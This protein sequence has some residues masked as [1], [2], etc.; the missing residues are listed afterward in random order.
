MKNYLQPKSLLVLLFS[1]LMLFSGLVS[2]QIEVE[3]TGALFTPEDLITNVFLGD[4]VEVTNI[5]YNGDDAAVG[6][7]TNGTNDVGMDRGIVMASGTAVTAATPNNAGGTSGG[8][9]NSTASDPDIT[10]IT[11]STPNDVAIYE[12]S[13]IPISDTLRFK[14]A[15]AS[16]EYPEYAC[17]DYNDAFG[18]F[19]S[20]PGISGPFSNNGINIAFVPDPADPTGTTFTD[21]PVTINNVNPGVVGINGTI[22]NCTPP[23]GSLDYGVYYNDNTGSNTLTYDGVLD[24]FIAQVVVTPCEEYTIKLA[25]CDAGDS[26][27]DSAVFLE[28]K[29]FGTGSLTVETATV[30]LDGTITESCSDGIL[31]FSFPGPVASD[32]HVDYT[33]FGEA[34]NGVDFEFIPGDLF[35][36]AGDSAVSVPVIAYEDGIAEGLESIGIDVQRDPCNRDTFYFYIRDNDIVNPELSDDTTVCRFEPVQLDGTLDIT[37]PPPPTFT[38]ETDYPIQVIDPNQPPPPGTPPTISEINVFGVQPPT[39]QEGVVKRVCINVDHGWISDIDAFLVSPGGQFLELTTDNGGSGNDYTETCFTPEATDPINFGSTAPNTAAPFTGDWQPE[40]VWSDLWDGEYP[41]N[42][43]WQLQIRDD[44]TADNGTLLGWSICFN[45]LYQI[46]Y[47]W[48]PSEGL[49]CDDC[50]DPIATPDSTT[51]YYLTATDTYG[52]E[53]YD[54]IT[55][56]VLDVLPAPNVTCDGVTTNSITFN[57]DE[58]PGANGYEVSINGGPWMSPTPGPL[59][60]YVSNLNLGEDVTIMVRST[61]LCDGL[62]DTLTCTTVDCTPP[63]LALTNTTDVTCNGDNNGSLSITAT[64]NFPPYE[65]SIAGIET[66]DTGVFSGLPGG[67]YDVL[68]TDIGGC[69]TSI[70][71]EILE[72][73]ALSSQEIVLGEALCNGSSE[74]SGTVVVSGGVQPYSFVWNNGSVD[75]V[76][77]NL[78]VGEYIVVVT[79]ANGCSITDSLLIVEPELLI[80]T[81]ASQAVSCNGEGDGTASVTVEG[82]VE[83]Y[84]YQWDANANNQTTATATGLNGGLYTVV[85]TD[86]QGCAGEA[87]VTVNEDPPVEL[88]INGSDAA[89]ADSNDGTATVE[90]QGGAGGVYTYQWDDPALQQTATATNLAPNSYTVV[91][92]DSNNCSE[93]ATITIE[94]PEALVVNNLLSEDASCAGLNDGIITIGVSGGAYP[95]TYEWSDNNTI[96]DSTRTD[97]VAGDYQIIITDGNDCSQTMDIF[98]GEPAPID[99]DFTIENV[100]CNGNDDGV[101]T[102]LPSGGSEPYTYQWDGNTNNQTTQSASNLPAGS[103]DVIVTDAN[104]CTNEATAIIDE[105]SDISLSLSPEDILCFGNNTGLVNTDISGGTEPYTFTWTGPNGFNSTD[106]DINSLYAGQYTLLVTDGLGCTATEQTTLI[107]PA[108]G[109]MSTMSP[110]DLICNGA[111]NGQ[112]VVSVTGGTG[113]FTYE[114]SN[115]STIPTVNNLPAG[116]HFVTITDAGNCTFV[117]T[118]FIDQQEAIIVELS[119]TGASCYNGLDGAAS[120]VNVFY[121]STPADIGSF[122]INWSNGENTVDVSNLLGGDT[123]TVTLTDALGCT[124]TESIIIDNPAEIGTVVENISDVSCYGGDDGSATVNG[125]GGTAPYSFEWDVSA[126]SQTTS[127][128][129]GLE[130]GEYFV[131]VTDGNDCS[132]TTSVEVGEPQRIEISFEAEDVLCAGQSNGSI[133]PSIEGGSPPFTYSWSNGATTSELGEVG[134]GSYGLTITDSNGCVREGAVSISAPTTITASASIEPTSCYKGRDGVIRVNSVSGGTPPYSYSIDD[135]DYH[136]GNIFV[137]LPASLYSVY[138]KDANGC[139]WQTEVNVWQPGRLNVY[140]GEDRTLQVGDSTQLH[141]FWEHE[142][143]EVEYTWLSPGSNYLVCPGGIGI[144]C[145]NPWVHITNT[146]T[147]TIEIKDEKG[148]TDED[149]VTITI[150]KYRPVHVPTAFTPNGDGVNDLLQ[151]HGRD[152]TV[153]KTFRVYDR[154]GEL[155]FQADD[156]GVNSTLIG[157]DGRFRSQLLNPG[158]YVWYVEAVHIDGEEEALNGHTTLLR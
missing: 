81:P 113:P 24:V 122:T 25:I 97:L 99:L 150:E 149:E 30:S 4:G 89:C 94:A 77:T 2:A 6:Y 151:V 45:P 59:Q 102:V 65:Y 13:F 75:S 129:T 123:Y 37:L 137:G 132:T 16:E 104:D 82:G 146:M 91:V 154:W 7:F 54:S 17:S 61:S 80:V 110:T 158:T 15:F 107:E 103:Y 83:P 29:S 153:I 38:N 114:W 48:T 147:F 62:I 68:V 1:S 133:V 84:I 3:P 20:G 118:A 27:Y 139:K 98:L 44:I 72:P 10:A 28:A 63:T 35:I 69:A 43:T 108:T 18:F 87:T 127:T 145:V 111:A 70:Q 96:T 40:G 14:Y 128:A 76:A 55:I 58:V 152:G 50:P 8:P 86:F 9:I 85:I 106:E 78:V 148:C 56:T 135:I 19:I 157:W 93:T 88:T 112:A 140:I 39:L 46:D 60:Q 144:N 131:T 11:T 67:I 79:D 23:N 33:I 66:N 117:D 95:Y 119:Q 136:G 130:P 105:S 92:T 31:S 32:F 71:V 73:D 52:C 26:A 142:Q 74:G 47:S 126:N 101:A 49:S 156:F 51:T 155:V 36:A 125:A 138:V 120:I 22:D 116:I 41:T 34:E 141:A 57:W 42:G 134:A 12:I 100:A 5:T 64:G 90:A 109:I 21:L 124:G 115:G 143:G 121:E 53:V